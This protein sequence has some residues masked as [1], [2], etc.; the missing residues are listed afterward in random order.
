VSE[1]NWSDKQLEELLRVDRES[2]PPAFLREMILQRIHTHRPSFRQRLWDWLHRPYALHFKPLQ[3]AATA[4][5]LAL[6]FWAGMVAERNIGYESPLAAAMA[7]NPQA[8]Y[9]IGRGLLAGDQVEAALPYLE[10]AV[11]QDPTS[12]EFSHWQGVAYWALGQTDLERQSYVRTV[13]YNPDHL[14][15][16]LNL[17]HNALEQGRYAEAL[18]SYQWVL[19]HD[20]NVPEALYNKALVYHKLGDV[21][22]EKQAFRDYLQKYRAGKWAG[23][24]VEHLHTLGDFSYRIYRIGVHRLVLNMSALLQTGSSSQRGEIERL[25]AVLEKSRADE[26]HIVTYDERSRAQAREVALGIRRQLGEYAEAGEL[27]PIRTSWFDT[28]EAL[29]DQNQ[30]RLSQSILVFTRQQSVDNRR[31]AT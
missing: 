3:L 6:S 22:R 25:A 16:H 31:N 19:D 28:A 17:G 20:P 26:L 21:F 18:A 10:K 29:S 23:R 30:T 5:V 2:E 24:A 13:R 1:N 7:E 15:T 8:S 11:E 9:L 14:P 12:A 4:S 27:M